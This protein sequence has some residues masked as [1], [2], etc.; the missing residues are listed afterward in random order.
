MLIL[1]APKKVIPLI[2][3]EI[4]IVVFACIIGLGVNATRLM[5]M[6]EYADASTR[7]KTELTIEVDGSSK[8]VTDLVKK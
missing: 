2:Y 5:A 4:T 8:K 1:R 3:K 7:G 6:K